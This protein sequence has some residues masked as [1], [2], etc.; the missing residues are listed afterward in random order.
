MFVKNDDFKRTLMM[1]YKDVT[2]RFAFVYVSVKKHLK[3]YPTR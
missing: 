3:I 2:L 1:E